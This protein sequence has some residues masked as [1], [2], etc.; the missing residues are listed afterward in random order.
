MPRSSGS[1]WPIPRYELSDEEA[2]PR[3][4]LAF[5]DVRRRVLPQMARSL[6]SDGKA[7]FDRKDWPRPCPPSSAR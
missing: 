4:R 3:I 5:H 7:A 2:A 6:Y 1:C